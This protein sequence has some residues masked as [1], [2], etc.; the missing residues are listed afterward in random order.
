MNSDMDCRIF[1]IDTADNAC[2]CT[3]GCMDTETESALKID[4]GR[5]IPCHTRKSNLP[6]WRTGLALYQ[7]SYIPIILQSTNIKTPH[8]LVELV[9]A[10]PAAA[11]DLPR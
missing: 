11:V 2:A 7:L 5:K 8:T 1:N 10:A 6:Q 3:W 4:S 9:K